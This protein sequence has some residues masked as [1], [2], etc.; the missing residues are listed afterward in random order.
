MRD[1]ENQIKSLRQIIRKHDHSY[2]VKN[3]PSIPDHEYD[4]LFVQLRS[5]EDKYPELKTEDSP[6]A[7]L[8]HNRSSS[9]RPI[10]HGLPMLSIRTEVDTSIAPIESF[11]S[12][13]FPKDS[14]AER[15][16]FAELKYDGLAINLVYRKG[17][18][19][20]A[21]TRGD[22]GVGEDVTQNVRA[23]RS[24]PL[25][26][27]GNAPPLI[28]IRGEVLMLRAEFHKLN[29]RLVENGEKPMANPRN[30]AA[31]SVRQKDPA[32]TA[33]RNL[34]FIP[35]SIGAFEGFIPPGTQDELLAVLEDLGFASPQ[36]SMRCCL[37][38]AAEVTE[39]LYAFYSRIEKERDLLPFEIDGVVYKVNSLSDQKK[40][41]YTGRE[42]NWAIAHK[43]KPEEVTT[44]LLDITVQVGRTGA[45]T[46]VAVLEAA[47]VGGVIVS[48]AT[49]HNE[50][51]VNRK[52]LRIGDTVI[53]RRAGDVIPEVVGPVL[54]L[55][56]E[57]SKPFVF[58]EKFP[59]CP[60]CGSAIE[61]EEDGAI[62]RCVGGSYCPAQVEAGL[63]HY[64]SRQACNIKGIA[65]SAIS[66]L[67]EAGEVSTFVDLYRLTDVSLSRALSR[68]VDVCQWLIQQIEMSKT[69]PLYR[70]LFAL[71]IRGAGVD[72]CRR[73][74]EKHVT[75]ERV[76]D[77]FS[78]EG[79]ISFGPV[80]NARLR[81]WFKDSRNIKLLEEAKELG[82]SPQPHKPSIQK[83]SKRTFVI[84]GSFGDVKRSD[85]VEKIEGAGDTT[86]SKVSRDTFAV[87]AGEN[88]G[89]KLK[90]AERLSVKVITLDDLKKLLGG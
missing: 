90:E 70:F 66:K 19:E 89:T 46:P 17:V 24:I 55:R 4:A 3:R 28:E 43:F 62:Y 10:S 40:L 22:G 14:Q 81:D 29:E 37:S 25:V 51:E 82:V 54:S 52:D 75:L 78:K 53:L 9:F 69:L 50:D 47:V 6:T 2:Y 64:V 11:L 49:L 84:T 27:T 67:I 63:L 85:I 56:K 35:Y 36:I 60:C 18:L 65:E 33:S 15:D 58:R 61:K 83:E 20:S 39:R 30:A 73:I 45:I 88:A 44:E 41:G 1:I 86:A 8:S 68:S 72:V 79:D 21:A 34:F 31:G 77:V 57:D 87:I 38:N 71:G 12:R 59:V 7:R 32:V 16:I 23:I 42:P 26:L 5:L 13:A 76:I 80:T 74:A 48:R